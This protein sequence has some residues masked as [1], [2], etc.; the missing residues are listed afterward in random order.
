MS[1]DVAD[2]DLLLRC[3]AGTFVIIPNGALAAISDSP[4]LVN[5]IDD[6][7]VVDPSH[8]TSDHKSTL[9]DLFK[10]VG[11]TRVADAGSLRVASENVDT[12]NTLEDVEIPGVQGGEFVSSKDAAFSE[13]ITSSSPLSNVSNGDALTGKGPGLGA[14]VANEQLI[15]IAAEPSVPA[16]TPRPSIK[17]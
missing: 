3:S 11:I 12:Q 17:S 10:M 1:V 13:K 16:I 5:F 14:N 2:V 4:H 6:D 8:F 15:D 7:S 9:G